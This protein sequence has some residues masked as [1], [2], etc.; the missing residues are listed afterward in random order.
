MMIFLD[1]VDTEESIKTFK[2]LLIAS[3]IIIPLIVLIGC[4]FIFKPLIK[5]ER[6]QDTS[7]D[8]EEKK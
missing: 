6:G 2:T 3:E 8:V 1:K 5:A 7:K 4:Y